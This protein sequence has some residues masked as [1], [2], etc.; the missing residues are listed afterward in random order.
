MKNLF[1]RPEWVP[2]V[3]VGM[4]VLITGATGG[5]GQA[6]G[7]GVGG[8]K[9]ALGL[10]GGMASNPMGAMQGIFNANAMSKVV[11][12]ALTIIIIHFLVSS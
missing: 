8:A 10:A 1:T 3:P 4:R 7:G 2:S 5:L 6:L 9:G 12:G 11:S